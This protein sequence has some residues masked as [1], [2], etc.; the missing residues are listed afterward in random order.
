MLKIIVRNKKTKEKVNTLN[1]YGELANCLTDGDWGR[2]HEDY[3][4]RD[5]PGVR[6]ICSYL[7]NYTDEK[8]S[9]SVSYRK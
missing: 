3:S 9:Y 2:I 5:N 8:Y 6:M 7:N 4:K 1:S